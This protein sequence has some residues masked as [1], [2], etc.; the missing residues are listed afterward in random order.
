MEGFDAEA[1]RAALRE[2]M[3]PTPPPAPL[4][5]LSERLSSARALLG[6]ARR[7]S[8]GKGEL[9]AL[10]EENRALRARVRELEEALGAA[11]G[12]ENSRPNG[13]ED[14]RGRP[15]QEKEQEKVAAPENPAESPATV[16]GVVAI[17][18]A[19]R[20]RMER[21]A[22]TVERELSRLPISEP[23]TPLLLR[24]KTDA[25]GGAAPAAA[26]LPLDFSSPPPPAAR[27]SPVP[28]AAAAPAS[29]PAAAPAAAA[30][31]AAALKAKRKVLSSTQS[32]W[33][34]RVK[35]MNEIEAMYVDGGV[36]T[37]APSLPDD[38]RK[39]SR[40]LKAQLGD[41]RS[42]IIR[43]ACRLLVTVAGSCGGEAAFAPFFASLLP[44][45]LSRLFVT[46]RPIA[47]A[48]DTCVRSALQR[49]GPETAARA[50][51]VLVRAALEDGHP[52]VRAR[53]CEYLTLVLLSSPPPASGPA[54]GGV[55]AAVARVALDSDR[56]ARAAARHL[57]LAVEVV[58]PDEAARLASSFSAATRRAI[59][60]D[61]AQLQNE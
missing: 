4:L 40:C 9:H 29:S 30:P 18:S 2:L 50:V 52:Q 33:N 31:F 35:A 17:Q 26:P 56:D 42:A 49:S 59:S 15:Q 34:L 1:H 22:L 41:L 5:R 6:A 27:P 60:D 37:S 44:S 3:T 23:S 57:F 61:R 25:A 51:P 11:A 55:A 21:R 38:L 32:C 7:E 12:G 39:L 43:E 54:R 20:G 10:R 58:W 48:A 13:S 16:R 19:F 47:D 53:S 36:A 14:G 46:V 28:A 8:C 45:L 24:L